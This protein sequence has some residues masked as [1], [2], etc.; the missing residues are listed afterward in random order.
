MYIH[1]LHG[2]MLHGGGY[3][4]LKLG[5]FFNLPVIAQ[6]HGSDVQLVQEIGYGAQLNELNKIKISKVINQVDSLVAVSSINAEN[7]IELGASIDKISVIH[8][9]LHIDKINKIPFKNQRSKLKTTNEDFLMISVGRN[10]PVKRMKLLF[11]AF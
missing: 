2:Q 5:N 9:G 4:A 8:N 11:K 10:K 7:L 1:L 3:S 6:S